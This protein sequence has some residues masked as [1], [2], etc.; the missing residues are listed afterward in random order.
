[1]NAYAAP[2]LLIAAGALVIASVAKLPAY[3]DPTWQDRFLN[4]DVSLEHSDELSAEWY[5]AKA[6]VQTPRHCRLDL[7]MGLVALGLGVAALFALRGVRSARDLTS[8]RS[9]STRRCFY[10]LAALTWLSFIPAEW[11]WLGYT[12]GRGD[13]PWWADSIGIPAGSVLVFG[14]VG[15]PVVL[16]GVGLAIRGAPLPV[17]LGSRPTFGPPYVVCV[18]LIVAAVLA[19]LVLVSGISAEPFLVPSALFT[20][21]LVL[22][23]RA[24]A[25]EG[26]RL[27]SR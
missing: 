27:T 15:L 23:G 22:S 11:F 26:R 14:I 21:Y 5:A 17:E 3:T 13:Y 4:V 10:S 18:G 19:L 8:L 9:P 7:G 6:A 12:Q 2:L 20:L 24:A 25:V 1:M 16:L